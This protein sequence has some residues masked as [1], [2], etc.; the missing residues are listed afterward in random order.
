MIYVGGHSPPYLP[1]FVRYAG[2]QM[3]DFM[4]Q[5][6]AKAQG[7][8]APQKL[9]DL[10]KGQEPHPPQETFLKDY[11]PPLFLIPHV[12]LRFELLEKEALVTNKML[13]KRNPKSREAHGDLFLNGEDLELLQILRDGEFL[14]EDQYQLTPKGLLL[15]NCP[16]SFFLETKVRLKPDQ[17]KAFSGLYRT[18]N[19]YCTQMEA[20]G[21]RR[22]TFFLDRPD[23]LSKYRTTIVGDK[24]QFPILLSNGNL[25]EEGDLEDGRHR[26]IWEDP[27]PKPCYL[28]ALVAG[29]LDWI[30]DSYFT[31]SNKKVG[32][33]IFVNKGQGER[34]RFA[35]DSLKQ[36]MKWDEDSYRLEYDLDLYHIVAVDDFNMGAME[37]K[38]L[39]IFNAKYVLASGE[40]ATDQD[41]YDIQGIIG[42]EY[43]HNWTG[44]RVTCRD[45]FQLS[46]KEG[47]TVFRD[48]EFSSDMNSRGVQ[49]IDDVSV[50][51]SRQFPQDSGPAAHPVRP[52]S[53]IAIDNFYTV[54]VYEKG[55]E[56]IRM[57]HTLLGP[58]M[59]K[60]GV[61]KYFE[62]F[63]GQ[64][65][66]TDDWVYAMELVSGRDFSQFKRWYDQ[67]GTPE[68][69]VETRY[70]EANQQ[71]ELQLSQKTIDP[72]TKKENL[73][74]HMPFQVGLL[75]QSGSALDFIYEDH[76]PKASQ[77][78]CLEL[79]EKV[80]TFI[81][82]NV[83]S[84][85]VLSLNRQFSAPVKLHFQPSEEHLY[86]LMAQ[87]PDPFSRW[88]ASQTLYSQALLKIYENLE[89]G[90]KPHLLS[91][92]LLDA[93]QA[94]VKKEGG[95]DPALTARLMSPP[96]PHYL[97]QFL[98]SLDPICLQRAY[99]GFYVQVSKATHGLILPLYQRL[100]E[101][102][103]GRSKKDV[104]LRAFKNGL[105]SYLFREDEQQGQ[106]LFFEQF[107]R[108]GNMTDR[109]A[110]LTRLSYAGGKA[111]DQ[112]MDIFRDQWAH[113]S[114][115]LNK[116]FSVTALCQAEDAFEKV[117]ERA[118]SKD[119]DSTNP[120]NLYSLFYNFAQHNWS[121]FHDPS[122]KVYDWFAHQIMDVDSRNPQVSS[123]LATCFNNWTQLTPPY[124]K[125]MKKALERLKD[126]RPSENL[127]EVV[128]GALAPISHKVRA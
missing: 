57:L 3:G 43:F 91:A 100:E 123:R 68:I 47:L 42:H 120:N 108:A 94:L 128:T 26:A 52:A 37:N 39:N 49:R 101:S 40:T 105:I 98:K 6:P 87:D 125:G 71:L 93:F 70:V 34:A 84:K 27:F 23:V 10:K 72:I 17:N 41:Y 15:K 14:E 112:A 8:Q 89:K 18:K 118:L 1:N 24:G 9:Q 60:K 53:Y 86:L 79:T 38:G 28:F 7:P 4:F 104:G 69:H 102:P 22:T 5:T 36:S 78:V 111:Y 58:D 48:Q 35:M 46:L 122:G 81:L 115:V 95:D 83:S 11:K 76:S 116:L 44:N 96:S 55:A 64:A 97:A 113:D 80:Q 56:V 12:D 127:Y 21:F 82:N 77:T 126:S 33:K 109:L 66:T 73:P 13:C 117:K 62:L 32:L 124:R 63:D 106:P 74:Y 31:R 67:R 65:V 20:Q 99:H 51:R 61:T 119:F 25:V 19:I 107:E 92:S 45:W 29:D 110:A 103:L 2:L 121:G 50:L 75:S 88:E 90:Q 30:E 59:F 114:L 85:P 54:T 16:E